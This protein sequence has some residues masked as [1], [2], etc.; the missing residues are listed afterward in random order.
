M[1]SAQVFTGHT[2]ELL[3]AGLPP[4]IESIGQRGFDSALVKSLHQ[5]CGAEHAA[6]YALTAD[7][8]MGVT[9]ASIDGS[10]ENYRK[11]D[12][13]L[14]A[15]LWRRDPTFAEAR[16]RLADAER[17]TVRT[18]IRALR[19]E[20]LREDVYGRRGIKDRVLIC[21][22]TKGAMIGLALSSSDADFS[23]SDHLASVE[24]NAPLLFAVLAKHMALAQGTV[25]VSFALTSL[26]EI[27]ACISAQMPSMPRREAE[28]CSRTIYGVTSLGIGLDLGISVETVMTYRKRA[29]GRLGIATQRELFLWYLDAWSRWPGR[30]IRTAQAPGGRDGSSRQLAL[31]N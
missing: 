7:N 15:G 3:R 6:V 19:D 25:D 9:T 5:I 13:Y 21:A 4:L 11:L 27:E 20:T 23:A 30:T 1:A 31:M 10:S 28:V 16:A 12:R 17:A 24:E 18:D 2:A 14:G 22:R 8:L 29:Y 26:D